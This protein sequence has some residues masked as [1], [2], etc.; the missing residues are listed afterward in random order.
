MELTQVSF[1][2]SQVQRLALFFTLLFL[3]TCTNTKNSNAKELVFGL[4]ALSFQQYTSTSGIIY[5][6]NCNV[7][8][9][10]GNG[11]QGSNDGQGNLATFN[12][13]TGIAVAT[14]GT[15]YIADSR[16]YK[17]R[18]ITCQN[19][20][21]LNERLKIYNYCKIFQRSHSFSKLS[22]LSF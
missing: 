2:R 10:V 13:P 15:I 1:K 14:D 19:Q 8:T 20:N 7:T 5:S 16:N 9:F 3:F 6:G 21:H 22:S 17:I 12:S 4:L 18:K 11:N